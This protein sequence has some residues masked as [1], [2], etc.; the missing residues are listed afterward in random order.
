MRARDGGM[1]AFMRPAHC[2]DDVFRLFR[3]WRSGLYDF[4]M[5]RQRKQPS[6]SRPSDRRAAAACAQALVALRAKRNARTV[7]RVPGAGDVPLPALVI[8]IMVEVLERI[9]CGDD[10]AL[11][12]TKRVMT[13]QP[14]ADLLGLSPPFLVHFPHPVP[15]PAPPWDRDRGPRGT[16][17]GPG[18]PWPLLPCL[19]S[20]KTRARSHG[21]AGDPVARAVT[22]SRVLF[23][24]WKPVD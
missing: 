2:T 17:S 23:R 12:V 19:R 7:I 15:L 16:G 3:L 8:P 21:C 14:A 5:A 9:A 18:R 13:T 22:C 6:C 4:I 24:A 11:A 10:A 1:M 20:P